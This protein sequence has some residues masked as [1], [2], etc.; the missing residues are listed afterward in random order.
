MKLNI[1]NINISE[2]QQHKAS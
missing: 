1:P 2:Q